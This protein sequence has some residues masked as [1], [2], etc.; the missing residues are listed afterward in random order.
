MLAR[1]LEPAGPVRVP[2]PMLP[3]GAR[4]LSLPASPADAAVDVTADLRDPQGTIRQV[5]FGTVGTG[6]AFL[7]APCR[8]ASGSWR[9]WSSTNP[10]VSPSR[11]ATGTLRTRP[12]PPSLRRASRSAAAR[13]P[14]PRAVAAACRSAA[15]AGSARRPPR[16]PC[17]AA[18]SRVSTSPSAGHPACSGRR[19][20]PTPDQSRCSPIRRRPPPPG[21]VGASP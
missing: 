15:G 8:P 13:A 11:T 21:P 1:R 16:I 7:R 3:A 10:P 19:S 6:G 12:P 20:Q 17:G 9:R 4:W 14:G 2:G 5:A 18:P